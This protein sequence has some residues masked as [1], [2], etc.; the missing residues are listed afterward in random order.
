MSSPKISK[1]SIV[2]VTYNNLEYTKQCLDSIILYTPK[3]LYEIIIVDNGSTDETV[4]YVKNFIENHKSIQIKLI[5]NKENLGF[6]KGCNQ[7][8]VASSFDNILFLNNDTIVTTNWLTN[9]LICLNSSENIG[10]VGPVTNYCSNYQA[11]KTTYSNIEEMQIF[12]RQFNISDK[13]LWEE[14]INLIGFCMLVR[15]DVLEQIGYFDEDFSP[16]N[17]EDDDLSLRI[18]CAGY[19]LILCRDTFIHHHGSK[20]FSNDLESQK[21]FLEILKRN[22]LKFEKKWG[23]NRDYSLFIRYDLLSFLPLDLNNIN[24]GLN[25]LD[26]GCACG[27]TLLKIKNMCKNANLY[28]IELNDSAAKI[29]A[30]FANI[31]SK[32]IENTDLEYPNNFFNY[33]I[34][35]DILEHLKDPWSLMYKLKSFLRDDGFVLCSVPNVMHISVINQ[36]FN[37]SWTYTQAGILD[38]THLRFFTLKEILELFNNAGYKVRRISKSVLPISAEE[39]NLLLNLKNIYGINNDIFDQMQVYQYLIEAIK[40]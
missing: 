13:N 10:A 22:S 6:P 19:K 36:L 37:G 5:E 12:A 2:I 25:F 20:T 15:R 29:A 40:K 18:F 27:A 23:F 21:K 16:G 4:Y 24:G 28:G 14:R 39:E 35:G 17:Y 7:G 8:I 38:K 3:D 11:I 32:D 26:V 33:I 1:V 9:L 31:V 30:K 34:L